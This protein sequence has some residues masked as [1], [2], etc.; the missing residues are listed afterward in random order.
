MSKLR[1]LSLEQAEKFGKPCIGAH[2]TGRTAHDYTLEEC[3]RCAICG[4]PATNAHHEPHLGMGGRNS[5][6]VLNADNESMPLLPS[7][8]ALCGSGTTGC[9]GLVHSGRYKIAWEWFEDRFE[10]DWWDGKMLCIVQDP[11]LYDFGQWVITDLD[12][13]ESRPA[14]FMDNYWGR[15]FI[16]PS[17]RQEHA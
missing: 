3:A 6:F 15:A 10:R 14:L 4:R 12:S 11:E 17:A 9:H 13:G 2:Y 1:G 5:R 7:L 16:E 8:I